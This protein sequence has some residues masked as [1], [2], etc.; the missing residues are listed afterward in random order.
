MMN[1][2]SIYE[3]V[4][5]I[6]S[7]EISA[8]EDCCVYLLNL[9]DLVLIDTGAGKSFNKLV[10][11]IEKIGLNPQRISAVILTHCHI[12]HVGAAL[13][14]RDMYDCRIIAH[15]LDSGPLE[16]GNPFL[17]GASWYNID[18]SPIPIDVKL[19]QSE[20][21][22]TFGNQDV[23]C[24]HTPGHTPGSISVYMDRGGKRVLF[25][26]DI[27]GPFMDIMGSDMKQ[28]R[29][30][31]DLLLNLNADILCE[32]HFGIFS[33]NERAREYIKGYLDFYNL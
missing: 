16:D 25:G 8:V 31:M 5:L 33:P 12:D 13:S 26:Q 10:D 2:F 7:S 20:Q 32:G 3:D 21:I 15:S 24:L 19:T 22:F 11:N 29:D 27:H 6:G 28:W 17:T 4:Y 30:S 14:F 1:P 23:V 9:D 18:I